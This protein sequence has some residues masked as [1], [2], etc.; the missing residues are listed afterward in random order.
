MDKKID[1]KQDNFSNKIILNKTIIALFAKDYDQKTI[2]QFINTFELGIYNLAVTDVNLQVE[3]F[4]NEND[5]KNIIEKNLS[6][7]RVFLGP[8]KQNMQLI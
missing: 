5:L 8:Y 2:K 3:L 1:Q 4:E 6:L 7:G